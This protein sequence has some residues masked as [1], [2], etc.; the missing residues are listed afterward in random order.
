MGITSTP[1]LSIKSPLET[2]FSLV[3]KGDYS[4]YWRALLMRSANAASSVSSARAWS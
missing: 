3:S 1:S 2:R 4:I